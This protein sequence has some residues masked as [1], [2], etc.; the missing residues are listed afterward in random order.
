MLLVVAGVGLWGL[1]LCLLVLCF[2]WCCLL[3]R[4]AV[5][6]VLAVAVDAVIDIGQATSLPHVRQK[7]QFGASVSPSKSVWPK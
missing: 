6:D 7:H 5:G 2:S 4:L 3:V 1:L